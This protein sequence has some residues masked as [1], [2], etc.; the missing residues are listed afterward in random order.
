MINVVKGPAH[1][2]GQSDIRGTWLTGVIAGMLCYVDGTDTPG[3]IALGPLA[4]NKT[5][6]VGFAINNSTDGD[7]IESGKIALYTLDGASVI[8]TDQ[9]TET[10]NTTNYPIGKPVYMGAS[11]LVTNVATNQVSPI[12]WVEGIRSLQSGANAS[13]GAQNYASLTENLGGTAATLSY[14][15]SGQFNTSVVAIKLAAGV[16]A[17]TG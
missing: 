4:Q 14:N 3:K 1:S 17:K 2:L 13:A 10:V 8:E 5:G 7:A 6:I 15:Y 12:G 9:M 16:S 11:G